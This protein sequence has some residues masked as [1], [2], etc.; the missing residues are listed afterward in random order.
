MFASVRHP[1]LVTTPTHQDVRRG[2]LADNR[3]F[4]GKGEIS[5][6]YLGAANG[7]GDVNA[8]PLCPTAHGR[9]QGARHVPAHRQRPHRVEKIERPQLELKIN[10]TLILS[11]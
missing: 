2:S 7:Q 11:I 5:S 4:L 1:Q 6:F 8:Y 10:H 3:M 9:G